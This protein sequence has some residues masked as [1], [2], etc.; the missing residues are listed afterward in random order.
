MER[1]LS[2][3]LRFTNK[4]A[5]SFIERSR[6]ARFVLKTSSIFGVSLVI[7][8]GILTPAQSVLGAI[9]GLNVVKQ[10]IRSA[11]IMGIS[12]TILIFLFLIQPFGQQEL[13]ALSPLQS[14]SGSYSICRS[15]STLVFTYILLLCSANKLAEL[16]RIRFVC[17]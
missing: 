2:A 7:A 8:D 17:S 15:A 1:V 10:D 11:T 16:R 13:L 9:Q 6:I 4:S 14:L 3:E 5:R 12:C